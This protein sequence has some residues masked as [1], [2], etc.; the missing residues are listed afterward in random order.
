MAYNLNQAR[1]LL[2][3]SELQLF[4]ASRADALKTLTPKQLAA[5]ITRTRAQ[6][7]KFRDL[8]RRQAVAT[9]RKPGAQRSPVGGDNARTQE[10]ADLFAE[11]LA[12]FEAQLV[13]ANAKV[14]REAAAKLKAAEKKAAD[15]AKAAAAKEKEKAKAAKEK[16]KAKAA[17]D[18]AAAAKEKDKAKTAKAKV[19]QSITALTQAVKRAAKTDSKAAAGKPATRTARTGKAKAHAPTDVPAAAEQRLNPLKAK[20]IN[21]KIQAAARGS[22]ARVQAKKDSR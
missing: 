11:V 18:K 14:E 21:Q 15:K 10:K 17:K 16:E 8:Y 20:P 13:K 12:R 22:K 9:S 1:K 7:D 2:T 19:G 6:R 4:E 3:S 5:K